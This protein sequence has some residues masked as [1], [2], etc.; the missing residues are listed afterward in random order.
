MCTTFWNGLLLILLI[1]VL[2]LYLV[3]VLCS[4]PA[5]MPLAWLHDMSK[6][7]L[8]EL[9]S[10]LGLK[11]DGTLDDLRRRVKENGPPLNPS[12]LQPSTAAKSTL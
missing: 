10:Q 8:E 1:V 6:E 9:A 12:C 11:A 7:Q 2:I 5:T 3:V 4:M